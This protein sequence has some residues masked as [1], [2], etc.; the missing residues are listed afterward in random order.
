MPSRIHELLAWQFIVRLQAEMW[1]KGSK[2]S[3]YPPEVRHQEF[4]ITGSGSTGMHRLISLLPSPHL[5][6]R[7]I[8]L[9]G[10]DI[11]L[12]Q[13][14]RL[15]SKNQ[16]DGGLA[17]LQADDPFLVLEV[18]YSEPDKHALKKA[19]DYIQYSQG[20]IIYV[21][22]VSVNSNKLKWASAKVDSEEILAPE[23]GQYTP[24]SSMLSALK[25]SP[26]TTPSERGEKYGATLPSK[27]EMKAN[28]AVMTSSVRL[29]SS[30]ASNLLKHQKQGVGRGYDQFPHFKNTQSTYNDDSSEA[31]KYDTQESLKVWVYKQKILDDP[32]PDTLSGVKTIDALPII[33]CA[34]VFPNPARQQDLCF[35]ILW[36]ELSDRPNERPDTKFTVHLDALYQLA[37]DIFPEETPSKE[38]YSKAGINH[39]A[40]RDTQRADRSSS[41]SS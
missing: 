39:R 40:A 15:I 38:H 41:T 35:D 34:E 18:A 29:G 17:F 19:K 21:I 4:F 16:P 24:S 2:D 27:L 32:N 11:L 33:D 25:C 22:V 5:L 28:S 20:R 31:S 37:K 10:T 14:G 3:F 7:L 36:S 23:T 1:N 30:T 13:D 9:L 26:P 12:R 8:S 6:I